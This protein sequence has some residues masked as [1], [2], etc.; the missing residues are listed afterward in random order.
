MYD[1]AELSDARMFFGTVI[2]CVELGQF[3][4]NGDKYNVTA[5]KNL[6]VLTRF[7]WLSFLYIAY[8]LA[9]KAF[10]RSY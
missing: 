6:F 8:A 9:S 7:T 4:L 10:L 5:G 2:T 3:I 1:T